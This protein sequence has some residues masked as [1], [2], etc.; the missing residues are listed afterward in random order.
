LPCLAITKGNEQ[1]AAPAIP[2]H[3]DQTVVELGVDV[4]MLIAA[5]LSFLSSSRLPFIIT[6]GNRVCI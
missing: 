3:A 4:G 5:L 2:C 1:R 6:A